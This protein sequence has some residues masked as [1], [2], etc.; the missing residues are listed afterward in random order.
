[1][2][3]I[4][5]T[6]WVTPLIIPIKWESLAPKMAFTGMM[7][8]IS[9]SYRR[10]QTALMHTLS[11]LVGAVSHRRWYRLLYNGADN[12]LVYR[13]GWA[14]FDKN[15]PTKLIARS[16]RP[17]FRPSADWEKKNASAEVH[18]APNVVFVEG[19]VKDGD[20]YLVYYGAAD[21]YVGVAETHLI[22]HK[23]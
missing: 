20:R 23:K 19:M 7:Q 1:M 8:L 18:Q 9:L 3:N 5:C 6:T 15:D 13:T 14:L 2:A 11:N 10:E 17:I 21:S 22:N 12:D 4:G 16:S